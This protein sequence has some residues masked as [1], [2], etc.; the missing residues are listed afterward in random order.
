M[1]NLSSWS[2]L[3]GLIER[4]LHLYLCMP[5]LTKVNDLSHQL[6]QDMLTYLVNSFAWIKYK[7]ESIYKLVTFIN[8]YINLRMW[9]LIIVVLG[10]HKTSKKHLNSLYWES[11]SFL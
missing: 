6:V 9:S 11:A 3:R 1:L 7:D 8:Y 10:S 5:I 4:F 2:L